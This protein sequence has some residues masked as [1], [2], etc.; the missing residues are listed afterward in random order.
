MN[1]RHV[2]KH[3]AKAGKSAAKDRPPRHP[4]PDGAAVNPLQRVCARLGLVG[5]QLELA[6]AL[7]AI[8]RALD[9]GWLM[10]AEVL[11]RFVLANR[12]EQPDAWALRGETALADGDPASA[13]VYFK[14]ALRCLDLL[15]AAMDLRPQRHLYWRALAEA[16]TRLNRRDEAEAALIEAARFDPNAKL[17]VT[18][19]D[20]QALLGRAYPLILQN[21]LDEAEPLLR[22]VL[23]HHPENADARQGLAV[24]EHKRGNHDA[25]LAAIDRALELDANNAGYWNNRGVLLKPLGAPRLAE[26]IAAYQRATALNPGFKEAYSNLADALTSDLRFDEAAAALDKALALDPNYLGAKINRVNLLKAQGQKK[27]ALAQID[28]ILETTRH[29]EALNL[30][31]ALLLETGDAHKAV[32]VLEEARSLDGR[33]ASILNNLGNAYL[34]TARAGKAIEC[35]R[36]AVLLAPGMAEAQANLALALLTQIQ[37]GAPRGEY[38]ALAK[39]HL[40]DAQSLNPKLPQLFVAEGILKAQHE[41]DRAAAQA[42]YEKAL[43]LQPESVQALSGLAS[44]YADMGERKKARELLQ[45][46]YELAPDDTDIA[47]SYIFALNYDPD[48]TPEEIYQAALTYGRHIQNRVGAPYTD[49]PNDRNPEKRLKVGF[50]SGDFRRHPVAYFTVGLFEHLPREQVEVY[51]YHNHI[52]SDDMTARTKAAVDHWRTIAEFSTEQACELIRADGIDILIDLSGHTGYHRLDVFAKKPAPVQVTWLGFA[53]TTGLDGLT[54]FLSKTLVPETGLPCTENTVVFDK[55]MPWASLWISDHELPTTWKPATTVRFGSFHNIT[56]LNE[57]VIAAW[58]RILQAIPNSTLKLKYKQLSDQKVISTILDAFSKNG[59]KAHRIILESSSPRMQYLDA[60]ND[61][62]IALD[63]FPYGGI[64]TTCEALW[65]GT[66]VVTLI[67]QLP[68]HRLSSD[69]LSILGLE[70][71]LIAKNIDDYISKVISLANDHSRIKQFKSSLRDAFSKSPSGDNKK[72]AY[73][74]CQEL[75]NLWIR[76]IG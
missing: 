32:A 26:R 5:E 68:T 29:P 7:Q 73:M 66:P 76:E 38:L 1:P 34:A 35:Y 44:L 11:C 12:P 10:E 59:I 8:R 75:R 15:P 54:W 37:H 28:A 23:E 53:A 70:N 6:D 2:G 48:S 27:A 33:N 42:A 51:A 41:H 61:I 20:A 60:Y 43:S 14:E 58:S 9:Q 17:N 69:P 46:A 63:P 64:T 52:A 72:F 45:R 3:A 67:G 4:T 25:A 16:N 18:A 55:C 19:A 62:D 13:R 39:N 30:K 40:A 71:E 24:L 49:W 36:S 65:M 74:L 21:R 57:N 31:G 22:A 56:K 50:V 47:T